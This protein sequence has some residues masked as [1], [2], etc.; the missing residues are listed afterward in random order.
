MN[1]SSF[2]ANQSPN[3]R[4]LHLHKKSNSFD[5][6][7]AS[8]ILQPITDIKTVTN[9]KLVDRMNYINGYAPDQ[10]YAQDQILIRP[11]TVDPFNQAF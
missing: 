2:I 3:R 9:K 6:L 8:R 5:Y 4:A 10:T 11:K 7:M 1:N